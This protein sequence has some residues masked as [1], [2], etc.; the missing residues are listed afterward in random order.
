MVLLGDLF[1]LPLLPK[2]SSDF[3]F[4]RCAVRPSGVRY[5]FASHEQLLR[6]AWQA[7]PSHAHG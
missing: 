2:E 4:V 7:A 3:R 6:R 5:F 1:R